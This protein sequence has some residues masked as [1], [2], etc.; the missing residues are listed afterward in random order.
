M[1]NSFSVSS[2][3]SL[4]SSSLE[5]LTSKSYTCNSLCWAFRNAFGDE[6]R[7]S[8]Y[9]LL[10]E[11]AEYHGINHNKAGFGVH[12]THA[13]EDW[14]SLSIKEQYRYRTEMLYYFWMSQNTMD[15]VA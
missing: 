12:F 7:K 1:C 6:C 4:T 11:Y 10:K 8:E 9:G 5:L 14:Y 3:A 2:I 15:G 13:D